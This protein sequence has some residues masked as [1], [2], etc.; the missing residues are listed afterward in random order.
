MST[1]KVSIIY[2]MYCIAC[3]VRGY[4]GPDIAVGMYDYVSKINS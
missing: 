1:D 2:Y 4:T 3:I